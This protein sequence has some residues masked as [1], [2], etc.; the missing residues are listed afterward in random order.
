M[1]GLIKKI[2][3]GLI[4]G[5]INGS[6]H[7]KCVLLSNHRG[8]IQPSLINLHSNKYSQEF[9]YYSFTVKVDRYIGSCN[10]LMTCLITY[11]FQIK[12]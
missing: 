5:L 10:T 4:A 6:N 7:A 8:M 2:F 9:H 11:E 12:Q 3:V 1:F